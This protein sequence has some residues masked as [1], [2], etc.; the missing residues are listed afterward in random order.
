MPNSSRIRS[1]RLAWLFDI[2]GTLLVTEGASREA[3]ALALAERYGIRDD[4]KDIRFDGR[5]EPLIVGDV[6]AKHGLEFQDGDE[7][8]FWHSVFGHMRQLLVAPRGR[9]LPGAA[10]L[11]YR[12]AAEPE[13][14]MGLLTGNMTEMA[15]IKLTRF[16]LENHFA[17]GSFGEQAPDRN[18]LARAAVEHVGREYGLS[19]ER[20]VV[21]GDTEHDVACA[22]YAGA[23]VAAVATGT[24]TR[25]ELEALNPDL[26]LDGLGHAEALIHW[27]RGLE[28]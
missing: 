13:W 26:V 24:R 10:E 28:A 22:R 18:L 4:L 17:F 20:C 19:P 15:H 21:I 7:A 3:F 16:G 11:L 8:R 2:D 9:L 27:A 25:A 23:R 5:T 1:P 14:V 12:V 6:L